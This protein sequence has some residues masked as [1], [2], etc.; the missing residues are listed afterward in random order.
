MAPLFAKSHSLP[1]R[2]DY[3]DFDLFLFRKARFP[4][5]TNHK[6]FERSCVETELNVLLFVINQIEWTVVINGK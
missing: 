6:L 2:Q 1:F 3:K 5:E 4:E